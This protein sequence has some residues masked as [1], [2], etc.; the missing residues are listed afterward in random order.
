MHLNLIYVFGF[1]FF[2]LFC[3]SKHQKLFTW[4][5]P[6]KLLLVQHVAALRLP[7][8]NAPPS[9]MSW[10]S[11]FLRPNQFQICTLKMVFVW[12]S[13]YKM[14]WYI[15]VFYFPCK[16]FYY[17]DQQRI[18]DLLNNSMKH[19]KQEF[20][21]PTICAYLES[22]IDLTPSTI[23]V[24]DVW[25]F[26]DQSWQECKIEG[27]RVALLLS[28][29]IQWMYVVHVYASNFSSHRGSQNG[30]AVWLIFIQAIIEFAFFFWH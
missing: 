9:L 7:Q 29:K 19:Q 30:A 5:V 12:L 25:N 11:R 8:W 20:N 22:F 3:F 15:N 10:K 4:K 14:C 18:K 24:Y 28:N 16:L 1:S 21:F 6:I 23:K 17:A 2:F 27:H 13:I 26:Y